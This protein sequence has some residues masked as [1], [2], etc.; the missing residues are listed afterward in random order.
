MMET[1]ISS[2]RYVIIDEPLRIY[3]AEPNKI[4]VQKIGVK[5][6]EE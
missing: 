1:V 4:E 3:A 6:E 5:G 2:H